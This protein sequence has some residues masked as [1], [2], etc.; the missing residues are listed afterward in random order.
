MPEEHKQIEELV[1]KYSKESIFVEAFS[2]IKID[3]IACGNVSGS[4][5]I[6]RQHHV[7]NRGFIQSAVITAIV[8]VVAKVTCVSVAID[9]E[10]LSLNLNLNRRHENVEKIVI[11][12]N[13]KHRG[14]RTVVLTAEVTDNNDLLLATGIITLA[15]EGYFDEIPI[16]W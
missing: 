13:I 16:K 11:Q 10:T 8:D 4:L 5:V 12:S 2:R 9:A 7:T 1:R 3:Q 15:V 14:R 6:D